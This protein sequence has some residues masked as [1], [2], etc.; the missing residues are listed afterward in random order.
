MEGPD[1]SLELGA[2]ELA[3]AVLFMGMGNPG[4]IHHTNSGSPIMLPSIMDTGMDFIEKFSMA[5]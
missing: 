2:S 1:I 5:T 3:G 4:D